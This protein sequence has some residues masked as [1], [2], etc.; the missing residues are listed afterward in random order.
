MK[1]RARD[2]TGRFVKSEKAPRYPRTHQQTRM[3]G[4]TRPSRPVS[5]QGTP[6]KPVLTRRRTRKPLVSLEEA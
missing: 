4:G 5:Q 6:Q 1:P 3:T 2:K